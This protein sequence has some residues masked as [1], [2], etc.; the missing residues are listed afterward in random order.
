MRP[1]TLIEQM[2]MMTWRR[3]ADRTDADD[4]LENK[5]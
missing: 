4:D 1:T 2:Q 3:T 5:D